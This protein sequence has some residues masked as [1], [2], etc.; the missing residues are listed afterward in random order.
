MLALRDGEAL[1][2]DKE[3]VLEKEDLLVVL[4]RPE[5]RTA[6]YDWLRDTGFVPAEAES[7]LPTED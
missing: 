3:L 5:Q 2:I 7:E 4:V 6:A 1:L